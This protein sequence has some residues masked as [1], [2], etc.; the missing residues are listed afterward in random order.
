MVSVGGVESNPTAVSNARAALGLT[1]AVPLHYPVQGIDRWLTVNGHYGSLVLT[2]RDD[3]LAR[4]FLFVGSHQEVALQDFFENDHARAVLQIYQELK[5]AL[6]AH[7]LDA[8]L[9]LARR[10]SARYVIVPWPVEKAAY[11]DEH[12]SLLDVTRYDF[13][14]SPP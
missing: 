12:F 13:S 4:H 3:I 9:R 7:D 5:Q 6:A 2:D 1:Y 11:R 14:A 8:T 10:I